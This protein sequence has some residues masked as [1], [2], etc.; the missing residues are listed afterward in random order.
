MLTIYFLSVCLQYSFSS[1]K[2]C[3][4]Y[5]ILHTVGRGRR[6]PP[7]EHSPGLKGRNARPKTE[8]GV[9]FRGRGQ[10]ASPLERGSE[11]LS[12]A[13]GVCGSAVSSPEGL[14]QKRIL[15]HSD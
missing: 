15:E 14:G 9:R 3:K 8:S 1:Q 10:P 12:P 13:I 11:P 7:K 2:V 5:S 6:A 4:I